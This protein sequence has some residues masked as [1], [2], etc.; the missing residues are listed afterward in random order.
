MHTKLEPTESSP[1][2]ANVPEPGLIASLFGHLRVSIVATIVLAV[3]VCGIYP[4]IVWG[5]A[6]IAFPHEANGIDYNSSVPLDKFKDGQG[7]LDEVKLIK[8]FN[9]DKSPLVFTA[10]EPVP[11]DAVTGSGSGLDPHI[12][13]DYAKVQA[14]RVA[15]ARGMTR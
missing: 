11:A 3:V 4:L 8:A 12:S 5:L 6:Q 9:D 10:R 14:K 2:D 1:A 13:V 15:G 7:N